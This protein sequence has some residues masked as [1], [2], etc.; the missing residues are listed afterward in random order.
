MSYLRDNSAQQD[1]TER[2]A[3]CAVRFPTKRDVL[4]NTFE[5]F[6]SWIQPDVQ[7]VIGMMKVAGA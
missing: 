5:E 2:K 6:F 3:T 4:A 7:H 1:E